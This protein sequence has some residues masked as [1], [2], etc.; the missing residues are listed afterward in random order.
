MFDREI[1]ALRYAVE[2]SGMNVMNVPTHADVQEYVR[3]HR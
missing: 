3:E 2:H 1:D